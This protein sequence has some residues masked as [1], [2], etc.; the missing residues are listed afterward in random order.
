MM[1]MSEH[2]RGKVRSSG[3]NLPISRSRRSYTWHALHLVGRFMRLL[4]VYVVYQYLT[5]SGISVAIFTCI[6][7]TTA[8]FMFLIVHRPWKGRSL[9]TYQLVPSIINGAFLSLSYVLWGH[10]LRACGP[11]RTIMAEYV[12]ALLGAMSTLILGK[13]GRKWQKVAGLMAMLASFYFLSQGWATS[14]FSPF[15]YIDDKR[16]GENIAQKN[17]IGFQSMS[18]V[19]LGG[20][21]AAVFRVIARRVSLKTQMK[22][23]LHVVTVTSAAC[24]LFPVAVFEATQKK[25]G[26]GLEISTTVVGI[27][28]ANSVFGVFLPFYVDLMADERLR[29]P[30]G[31]AR[32][33]LVTS[34]C[35]CILEILYGMDFSFIGFLVCALSLGLGIFESTPLERGHGKSSQLPLHAEKSNVSLLEDPRMMSRVA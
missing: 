27:F 18:L 33:L 13:G 34:V 25:S 12:G 7:A 5:S 16:T 3:Y 31:S 30:V 32:H 17:P 20:A 15:S 1:M 8:A 11:L 9:T 19:F 28:L 4:S 2:T 35:V 6:C 26:I 23:R 14:T 21:F 24:F 10:G 22:R 29:I